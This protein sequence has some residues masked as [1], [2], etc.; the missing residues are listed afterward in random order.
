MI[1]KLIAITLKYGAVAFL[2]FALLF[3]DGI[4]ATSP[5]FIGSSLREFA[6][7]CRDSATQWMLVFCLAIYFILPLALERHARSG[8]PYL[9]FKNPNLWLAGLVLLALLQYA[10]AYDMASHSMQ[11]PMLMI[12]IVFGKAIATW[13]RWRREEIERRAAFLIC[14]FICLLAASALWQRENGRLFQYHD[15]PRWSGVWDNPNLYGLLM[16]VGVVLAAGQIARTRRWKMEDRQWRKVV[17]L[18]LCS[19]GIFLCGFGL[20]KSYSVAHGWRS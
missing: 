13:V 16:G 9:R 7:V 6:A 2:L 1:C 20:F 18:I 5:G 19:V 4:W 17:C 14:S 3:A 8:T 11:I 10:L 12:G 15:I